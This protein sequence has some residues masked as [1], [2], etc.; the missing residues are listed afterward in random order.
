MSQGEG[1]PDSPK[2]RPQFHRSIPENPFVV[3]VRGFRAALYEGE[4]GALRGALL[5]ISVFLAVKVTG[6]AGLALW[7]DRRDWVAQHRYR[8][9]TGPTSD[10]ALSTASRKASSVSKP[11]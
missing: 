5:P 7:D 3:G 1:V 2:S 11:L 4:G 10:Q 9:S 8:L 6:E